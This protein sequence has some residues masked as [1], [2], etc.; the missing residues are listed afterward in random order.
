MKQ[1]LEAAKEVQDFLEENEWR[2]CFIGGIAL[3]RWAIPRNTNDV[4]LTIMT[5]IG[6]EEVVTQAI[7]ERF[8]SRITEDPLK[9]FLPRRIVLVAVQNVG[10]DISLGAL[11]FEESAVQR[12][13]YYTFIPGVTLKTCSAEDLIVFK[14]FANRLKDWGDIESIVSV[15]ERM[16][17][18][19]V[20]RYLTPLAELKEEGEIIGELE[21][22]RDRL[23]K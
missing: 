9:F 21:R 4:D 6:P 23:S 17:W 1:V 13:S 7:L 10:I 2:F 3:Q 16:D 14:A 18:E 11:E 19:Y 8:E 15:Q 20:Y 5:G 22:L 12:A